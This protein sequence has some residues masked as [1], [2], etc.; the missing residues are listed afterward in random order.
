MLLAATCTAQA[1]QPA[2]G[3][4]Q[5]EIDAIVREISPQRIRAHVEK[6]V[7]FGT[8]HTMSETESDTR[9]I[10]AAR[11][12]IKAEL[13]RCGAAAGGRLQVAFDSHVHR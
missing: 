1:A 5:A 3:K 9:G 10:G 12:R 2:I 11:R 7:S 8:R 13:E 6:L 4:R